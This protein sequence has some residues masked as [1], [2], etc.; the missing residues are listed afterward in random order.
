[1]WIVVVTLGDRLKALEGLVATL[2]G[3]SP[4]QHANQAPTAS[5]AS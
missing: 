2:C 1:M 4:V 3:L 5:V